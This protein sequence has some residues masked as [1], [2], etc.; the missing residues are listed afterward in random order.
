MDEGLEA[1][2]GWSR[3]VQAGAMMQEAGFP[4]TVA[5]EAVDTLQGLALDGT[6]TIQQ[7]V[8]IRLGRDIGPWEASIRATRNAQ[9][10][11]MKFQNHPL[12]HSR[13]DLLRPGPDEYAAMF[14]K[15]SLR[16]SDPNSDTLPGDKALNFPSNN[17]HNLSDF[18]KAKLQPPSVAELYRDMKDKNVV[19]NLRCLRVLLD[20]ADSYDTAHAYLRYYT[21]NNPDSPESALASPEPTEAEMRRVDMGLFVSY[22]HACCRIRVSGK[23]KKEFLTRVIK[24]I[25]MRMDKSVSRWVSIVWRPLL[26]VLD[27]PANDVGFSPHEQLQLIIHAIRQMEES[28]G[29]PLSVFVHACRII[30]KIAYREVRRLVES[31]DAEITESK[32][33]T[34][35]QSPQHSFAILSLKGLYLERDQDPSPE[36][37][38]VPSTMRHQTSHEMDLRRTRA[39]FDNGASLLKEVFLQLVQQEKSVRQMMGSHDVPVLE[40]MSV[41]KDPVRADHAHD[42]LLMLGFVG[43]FEE[44]LTVTRWLITEWGQDEVCKALLQ[45]EDVPGYARLLQPLCVYRLLAEPRL[46]PTETINL[47]QE[48]K[49]RGLEWMWPSDEA[50]EAYS[51]GTKGQ[52]ASRLARALDVVDRDPRRWTPE[53]ASKEQQ[54]VTTQAGN[55]QTPKEGLRAVRVRTPSVDYEHATSNECTKANRFITGAI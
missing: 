10:A 44:M 28:Q 42:Y 52:S 11:W 47:R 19:L 39:L 31:L 16:D 55:T 3:A 35:I 6:P 25:S 1:D 32:T 14:E 23:A 7:R 12:Q 34:G 9:E 26:K 22:I 27:V 36:Q 41:R 50:V 8:S 38:T 2:E 53:K 37:T 30:R 45:M 20:N 43:E 17:E 33:A 5:D 54:R 21:S 18:E 46:A 49:A 4:K 48:L 15:L 24:L 40:R 29:A 51:Q 13:E